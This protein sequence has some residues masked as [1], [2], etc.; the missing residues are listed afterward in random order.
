MEEKLI[1]YIDSSSHEH[2]DPKCEMVN[3]KETIINEQ[4]K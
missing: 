1:K 3:G 4:Q 2:Y